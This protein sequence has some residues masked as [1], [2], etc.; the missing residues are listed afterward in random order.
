[1]KMLN[2][3]FIDVVLPQ[4]SRSC[5]GLPGNGSSLEAIL[6]I[7]ADSFLDRVSEL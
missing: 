7:P 2:A 4:R 3:L 1:M 5:F 6:I